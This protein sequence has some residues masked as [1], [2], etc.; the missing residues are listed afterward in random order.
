MK[1][2]YISNEE[3]YEI[4][5][6]ST[7]V[8]IPYDLENDNV[9]PNDIFFSLIKKIP[10]YGIR[11][12]VFKAYRF[13]EFN[14]M[15]VLRILK[16]ILKKTGKYRK[17]S[18]LT[19]DGNAYAAEA[20]KKDAGHVVVDNV[21]VANGP[22]FL[23]VENVRKAF[24]DVATMRREQLPAKFVGITGS[25]GKTTTKEIL[26]SVLSTKFTCECTFENNNDFP[27]IP[28][29]VLNMDSKTQ[30]G[31][32]EMGINNIGDITNYCKIVKPDSGVIT[33]IGKSHLE[34]LHSIDQ[35]EKAK[36]EL[37]D[38]LISRQGHIF[39]NLDDPRLASFGTAYSQITTF[40]CR[41]DA[42]VQGN[43]FE[44]NP[45]LKIKWR[46]SL[47]NQDSHISQTRLSGTYNLTNIL[48]AIAIGLHY[49]IPL[50]MIH[51]AIEAYE[52]LELR[53][54]LI[55]KGSKRIFVDAYNANPT[56]MKASLES[57]YGIKSR[58]KIAIIGDMLELGHSSYQEHQDIVSLCK[59]FNFDR[60]V[61]I[62]NEFFHVKDENAGVFFPNLRSAK[63]WIK[64]QNFTDSDIFLKGSRGISLEKV[65]RFI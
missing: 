63:S 29:R 14:L 37:F 58:R 33:C 13:F 56:S 45:F 12:F 10:P 43:V 53:S 55:E 48:A 23:L 15:S 46:P 26:Q 42:E 50:K 34:F 54:Q 59:D 28:Q 61:F 3:L 18:L 38:Y 49:D 7:R 60:T 57:F 25:C 4:V 31:I 41:D 65:L 52:P 62:G 24:T 8:I 22:E 44:C 20:L 1:N 27:W 35:V 17:Y 11:K 40:G 21:K 39:L 9:N 30:F 51:E 6:S 16:I 36:K 32:F 19:V 2:E 47:N 5:R 64:K